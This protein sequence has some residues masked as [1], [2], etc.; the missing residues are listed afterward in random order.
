MQR[1]LWREK[2]FNTPTTKA[3]NS[4]VKNQNGA[5]NFWWERSPHSS[6]SNL[7]CAVDYSG[8]A[9]RDLAD[10]DIGVAFGFCV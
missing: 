7:F 8:N 6:N 5:V 4:K 1:T 9:G 3:G 2:V 10:D